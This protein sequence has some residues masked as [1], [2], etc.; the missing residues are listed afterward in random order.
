VRILGSR[1]D[2]PELLAAA[3][4]YLMP[5]T[6]EA[7][8]VALIEAMASGVPMVVSDI[9]SSAYAASFP[10]LTLVGVNDAAGLAKAAHDFLT[11]G[12]RYDRAL[13]AY[14]IAE[15]ERRYRDL[16]NR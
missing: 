11:V 12:K 13:D 6:I 9:P 15:T 2:V 7:H 16:I 14:D 3:D 1:K 5:S 4:L 10:G 8:S